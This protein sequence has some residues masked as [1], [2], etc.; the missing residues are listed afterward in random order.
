MKIEFTWNR[1]DGKT[2]TVGFSTNPNDPH[3]DDEE[4][5]IAKAMGG[6][7]AHFQQQFGGEGVP[8]TQLTYRVI[9]D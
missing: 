5:Q 8:V 6:A 7:M 1:P 4:M 2:P 3:K 9:K